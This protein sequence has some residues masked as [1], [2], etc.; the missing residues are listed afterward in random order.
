MYRYFCLFHFFFAVHFSV[1]S[2]LL[3]FYLILS[4]DLYTSILYVYKNCLHKTATHLFSLHFAPCQYANMLTIRAQRRK[5]SDRHKRHRKIICNSLSLC[6]NDLNGNEIYIYYL[7]L[8]NGYEIHNRRYN[9]FMWSG[10]YGMV[11]HI[12]II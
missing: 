5:I 7:Y 12:Y 10:K 8:A 4:P 2:I 3:I 6:E 1:H 11:Q 9:L